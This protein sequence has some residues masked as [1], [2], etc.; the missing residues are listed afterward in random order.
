VQAEDEI[1][2]IGMV[3]GAGLGWRAIDDVD[4]GSGPCP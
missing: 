3:I 1:A 4:V 2:A